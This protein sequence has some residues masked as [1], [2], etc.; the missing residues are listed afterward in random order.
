[1]W[2]CGAKRALAA[3][4]RVA[5]FATYK[6]HSSVVVLVMWLA[7]PNELPPDPFDRGDP[8]VPHL[9]GFNRPEQTGEAQYTGYRTTESYPGRSGVLIIKSGHFTPNLEVAVPNEAVP[10]LGVVSHADRN[11]PFCVPATVQVGHCRAALL[12]SS[13]SLCVMPGCTCMSMRRT[14]RWI[15]T[16]Y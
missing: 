8:G 6:F 15:C 16:T 10:I 3:C 2:L 4:F 11:Y 5:D 14:R 7:D 12:G 13:R 1:M 9:F